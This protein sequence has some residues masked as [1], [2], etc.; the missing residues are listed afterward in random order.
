MELAQN[1]VR[2]RAVETRDEWDALFEIGSLVHMPQAWSYGEAKRDTDGLH[3][4][5]WIIER[6][7]GGSV[8]PVA[9]CQVMQ[10][11]AGG[12]PVISRINRGPVF[13]VP[14]PDASM[15]EAV[16]RA[17]RR[18]RTILSRGVLLLAPALES[19]DSNREALRRAGFRPRRD[20]G[21]MSSWLDLRLDQ[22]VLHKRLSSRWRN[23]LKKAKTLGAQ[24]G[25]AMST[26]PMAWLAQEHE[27]FQHEKGFRG[28][29]G[30]F[31]NALHRHDPGK[32]LVFTAELNGNPLAALGLFR[33]G[34]VAEYYVGWNSHEGRQL[35]A[36]TLLLWHAVS[37]L[38]Q[39]GVSLLDLGGYSGGNAGFN[40]FKRGMRGQDYSLA[41]EWVGI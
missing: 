38:R 8:S 32:V 16:L 2:V 3:L 18:H 20:N 6:D 15:V 12:W 27:R 41:G 34:N 14:D 10:K 11:R 5:R 1:A 22:D 40:E 4:L 36:H 24:H 30:A 37:E 17:I 21:W 13:L 19:T 31:L 25:I 23:H 29:S 39:A 7:D 28:P 33:V 26:R 35:Q 9:L